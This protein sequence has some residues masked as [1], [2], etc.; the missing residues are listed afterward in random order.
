MWDFFGD[1]LAANSSCL[2]TKQTVH[3]L[4]SC[5]NDCSGDEYCWS[6]KN[7]QWSKDDTS[8]TSRLSS[9]VRQ[10]IQSMLEN[11]I[12]TDISMCALFAI[13][14]E[15]VTITLLLHPHLDLFAHIFS[16]PTRI[17]TKQNGEA[18]VSRRV[19]R[20]VLSAFGSNRTS[21]S[22]MSTF[23]NNKVVIHRFIWNR[24]Q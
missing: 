12:S 2:I 14:N 3:D 21:R 18:A 20:C 10:L 9:S 1:K 19:R 13:V 7:R 5:P 15:S 6:W 22:T 24:R 8:R 11:W 17:R 16:W 23:H 4:L